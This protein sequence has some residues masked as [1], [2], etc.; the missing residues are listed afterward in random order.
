MQTLLP[1]QKIQIARLILPIFL[2]FTKTLVER[3]HTWLYFEGLKK[4]KKMRFSTHFKKIFTLGTYEL[5]V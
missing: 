1:M 5:E 3:C 2:A 4:Y